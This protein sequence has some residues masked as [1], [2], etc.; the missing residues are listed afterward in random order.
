M[1]PGIENYFVPDKG[2]QASA[3]LFVLFE[4]AYTI[5]FPAEDVPTYQSAHS[6]ADDHDI[7]IVHYCSDC[8]C[9]TTKIIFDVYL[10]SS[11]S[12]QSIFFSA[13]IFLINAPEINDKPCAVVLLKANNLVEKNSVSLVP[14]CFSVRS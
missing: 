8:A 10:V 9:F 1:H 3:D 4:Y 12:I 6:A 13:A 2:L 14:R 5:S 7:K 11:I